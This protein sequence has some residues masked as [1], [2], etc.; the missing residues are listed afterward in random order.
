MI[1]RLLPNFL[2]ILRIIL[3]FFLFT[4]IR[5][6]QP[7]I[8]FWIVLTAGVT[9]FLDGYLARRFQQIS[10]LGGLLD[11]LAD[12][13]FFGALFVALLLEKYLPL[14]VFAVFIVRDLMLLLGTAF[15]KIKHIEYE[16]APT[17]LSKINTALQFSFGLIAV[18]CPGS[19]ILLVLVGIILVTTLLSGFLYF[20]RFSATVF[21]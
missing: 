17:F 16:F 20:L 13:M 18:L 5:S 2:S 12:K 21:E 7:V 3:A 15:I 11:P 9:D 19:A 8:A 1:I 14:W 10:A 6:H 4:H